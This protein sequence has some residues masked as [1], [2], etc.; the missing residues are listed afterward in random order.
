MDVMDGP[1][2]GYA[3]MVPLVQQYKNF[4]QA[5]TRHKP[6]EPVILLVDNDAGGKKVMNAAAQ[7]ARKPIEFNT[8]AIWTHI[9]ENLY[10]LRTPPSATAPHQS[11]IESLF[12]A[13]ILGKKLNGRSFDKTKAHG[14]KTVYGKMEFATEVV[15]KQSVAADFIGLIPLLDAI[16]DIQA[17]LKT[18]SI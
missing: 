16:R 11:D 1:S 15:G 17:D 13:G 18:R 7:V 4:M 12:S 9:I 8:P 14:D 3:P 10:L 6:P 5:F 2:S